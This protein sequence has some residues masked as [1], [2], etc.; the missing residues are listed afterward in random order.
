[1]YGMIHRAVRQMVL[2]R[3][4]KLAWSE[5]EAM[6]GIGQSELISAESYDDAITLRLIAG[7]AECSK[8]TLD[9]FL[10]EFGRY[11]IQ[12][13]EQGSFGA[14]LKFTGN[15]LPTFLRN[16]NRLHGSV[17][18][19]MPVAQM[20]SFIVVREED[21]LIELDYSSSRQGM[22]PFVEGLLQGLLDRF[23]LQGHVEHT[24]PETVTARFRIAFK[25]GSER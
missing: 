17:Q 5:I 24:Y 10:L 15:D 11:W 1:M 8:V 16:L 13:A 4:G 14:I 6:A 19:V 9:E 18:S 20:P 2:D 25:T 3:A 23:G 21:G 7:A 22:V 12:Y